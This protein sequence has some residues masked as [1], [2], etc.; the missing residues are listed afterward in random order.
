M[1]LPTFRIGPDAVIL[2]DGLVYIYARREIPD[3]TVREFSR[4]AIFFRGNKYYL[5]FRS[6]APRPYAALYELAPWPA[7]LHDQSKESFLYDE[8]F[9]AE[10][11][12]LLRVTR[13]TET[14]RSILL[15]LYPLLGFCWSSYKDRVLQPLGFVPRSITA[16]STMLEFVTCLVQGA[17]FGYLGGGI[18]TQARSAITMPLAAA[19]DPLWAIADLVLLVLLFVD[20]VLRYNQVLRDQES[21]DG[22][23]EWVFAFLRRK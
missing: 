9:V 20:C 22:F 14:L 21:L 18:V 5:R 8:D 3:W 2:R 15:P 11:D 1:Q 16:A 12:R 10:R 6:P 13:A 4:K 19:D 7:D 23:M 17:L